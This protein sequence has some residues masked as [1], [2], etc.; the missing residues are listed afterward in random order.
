[1]LRTIYHTFTL[2][3]ISICIALLCLFPTSH[4]AK[5]IFRLA[6]DDYKPYHWYDTKEKKAKGIF[7]DICD[8]VLTKKLGYK[9]IYTQYPWAR[10]QKQVQLQQ[11]DAFITTPTPARLRYTSAG[12]EALIVMKK[13]PFTAADHPQ[14]V[15][16]KQITNF[17]DL[18]PY[19]LL[20][21]LGSGWGKKNLIEDHNYS[22]DYSTKI[23]HVLQKLAAK[24]GDIFIEDALL[25]HYNLKLLG[26]SDKVV[27][28]PVNLQES[29]FKLCVGRRSNFHDKLPIIDRAIAEAR[30]EGTIKAIIE[31][32]K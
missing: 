25:I 28:L 32:W 15:A 5:P 6:H 31:R 8:E 29:D 20:D 12:A 4:A 21:Y 22:L 1:M 17:K 7:V 30:R 16:M 23:D 27:A 14:L 11:E 10:A 26:L 9:I 18:K 2:K 3:T 19:S 24:H 13:I